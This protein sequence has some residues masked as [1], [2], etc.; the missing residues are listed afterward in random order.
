MS[1]GERKILEFGNIKNEIQKCEALKKMRSINDIP[2]AVLRAAL[3]TE[4]MAIFLS[5]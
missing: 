5:E 3:N 1:V 2:H 4:R